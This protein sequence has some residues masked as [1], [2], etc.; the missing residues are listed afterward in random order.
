MKKSRAFSTETGAKWF[1]D[2]LNLIDKK[3]EITRLEEE[4]LPI[5]WLVEWEEQEEK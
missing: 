1:A 3:A 2:R 4:D 5:V